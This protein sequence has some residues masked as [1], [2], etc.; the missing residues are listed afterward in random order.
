M[1][2]KSIVWTCAAIMILT[3]I[4]MASDPGLPD[5]LNIG[6]FDRS[7]IEVGLGDTIRVEVWIKTDDSVLFTQI[8]VAT[9][10]RYVVGRSGDSLYAPFSLWDNVS[11]TPPDTG[12]PQHGW[13]SQR[14]LGFAYLVDP[15]D[16]QNWLMTNYQWW[17]IADYKMVTTSDNLVGNVRT[18][19]RAGFNNFGGMLFGIPDG[20][21]EIVPGVFFDSLIFSVTGIDTPAPLP[22]ET[23]LLGAY[24]NPFN[25]S[26]TIR[27]SLLTASDVVITIYNVTGQLMRAFRLDN[28]P[29][30]DGSVVWNGTDESGSAVSSGVYFYRMEAGDFRASS[31]V[32][33]LK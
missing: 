18:P 20:I 14:I 31:R 7:N 26:T 23:A 2:R 3:G 4:A 1:K 24:P 28:A 19:L 11:F 9:D 10:D 27:F 29:A 33:L 12:S 13:T 17:H 16:P 21:T 32:T 6:R 25:S 22:R 15:P 5:S 30:G 8:P